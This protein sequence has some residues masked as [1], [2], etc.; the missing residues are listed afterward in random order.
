M[1][2]FLVCACD[3]P[4]ISQK[5]VSK[6]VI[7]LFFNKINCEDNYCCLSQLYFECS[8]FSFKYK[9][10]KDLI[11]R[12]LYASFNLVPQG[13]AV[14]IKWKFCTIVTTFSIL[15]TIQVQILF[16]FTACLIV[17]YYSNNLI[18]AI[19]TYDGHRA[20]GNQKE[21]KMVK[22]TVATA[23]FFMSMLLMNTCI[24]RANTTA[25]HSSSNKSTAGTDPLISTYYDMATSI[26][27][28]YP[29][30]LLYYA[31]LIM[32]LQSASPFQ[33]YAHNNL[34]YLYQSEKGDF[35]KAIESLR[36][37]QYLSR[38]EDRMNWLA[39]TYLNMGVIYLTT[40][41]YD[42]ASHY[43]D[44]AHKL[45]HDL[46]DTLREIKLLR[47][48]AN[49]LIRQGEY[50]KAKGFVYETIK[51]DSL[52]NPDAMQ[53]TSFKLLGN[54]HLYAGHYS[55]AVEAY[56]QAIRLYERDNNTKSHISTMNN[57][58]VVY[59][60]MQL[61]EK[62][63]AVHEENLHIL[64]ANGLESEK[65]STLVNLGN[66]YDKLGMPEK[67]VAMQQQALE[68]AKKHNRP[69]RIA[70]T[71]NN[72]GNA[73]YYAG[74]YQTAYSRF[75]E[76]LQANR[77]IGNK[78][79]E[80]LCLSNMAWALLM[81]GKNDESIQHFEEA[82]KLS[83][84]IKAD[85][86]RLMA[87]DGLSHA[88]S[89]NDNFRLA[90]D[91]Q[92]KVIALYDSLTG[93]KT[94]NRI[95]ELEA[96][97]ETEKKER[98]IMKLQQSEMEKHMQLQHNKLQISR[99]HAQRTLLALIA[100]LILGAAWAWSRMLKSRK[101]R[102]KSLAV[103]AEREAGLQVVIQATEEERKR[104]AKDL[105]DGV[106]QALSGIKLKMSNFKQNTLKLKKNEKAI[107]LELIEH[108]DEACSEVRS[109][110]HQMM[111]RILQEAGLLPALD[112]MLEKVFRH[113]AIQYTFEHYGIEERFAE[114][115]EISLF[116]I[117][118]ELINNIIKHSEA[119]KVS[120]Q[121][122]KSAN[123]L[124]LLV[125]DNGKGFH[126]DKN[127]KEGLGLLSIN[128]R[129][130]TIHGEFDMSPSPQSGMLATIRIPL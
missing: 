86:K 74:D 94:R 68:L 24:L 67:N 117:C 75:Q 46:Q 97:Y 34:M 128:S 35:Q 48:Y 66:T 60:S 108:I 32:Q 31:G 92:A 83:A 130:E 10:I 80:A 15:L 20:T 71:T 52:H 110:S 122:F 27:N 45:V 109:I 58:A 61:Y 76:A 69:S 129:V 29:D 103:I 112:D 111:P 25:R 37:N 65:I 124:I 21:G 13:W 40:D 47:N 42:S 9:T 3:S 6:Q 81:L 14:L 11:I 82:L 105:H 26:K 70:Q 113:T 36:M 53:A 114:S 100:I 59:L 50:D 1:S 16:T 95:A 119:D 33:D 5:W 41:Q 55:Q 19:E 30:S 28:T 107:L 38:K 102:E 91:Y 127:A 79:E 54:L 39:D 85:D 99:L 89:R 72:L 2:R 115:L 7:F 64:E 90:Y 57:L 49:V 63:L 73:A 106:G 101:E 18:T 84:A 125:E 87:L 121:L 96:L 104:I 88:H 77:D 62:A 51:L 116:R 123:Q 126:Y 23:V 43:N 4:N 22:K 8:A 98:E 12:I 93:E 118:Q 44:K 120:V 56:Q 78:Q 17:S